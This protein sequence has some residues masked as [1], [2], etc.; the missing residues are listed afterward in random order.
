[1]IKNKL[2]AGLCFLLIMACQ[3][4]TKESK[5]EISDVDP[6]SHIQEEAVKRVLKQAIDVAGG[7]DAWINLKSMKYIKHGILYLE[8]STEESNMV[9]LH[10]YNFQPSFSARISWE[11]NTVKHLIDH[12]TEGSFKYENGVK[13]DKSE[14]SVYQSVMSSLY[15]LG[16]PFKLLDKG[17]NLNYRGTT[18]LDDSVQAEVIYASYSPIDNENHSTSD[19]WYYYFK[20]ETGDFLGAMVYHA[21][22]Y[23]YIR[24]LE[25]DTSTSIKWHAHRQS[26]RTDSTRSIAFLRAEFWYSD[27]EVNY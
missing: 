24:N 1:M 6:Y 8:D 13:T 22:T 15:V 25:F 21:P 16:M 3:Q 2:I 20:E 23:A 7:L 4:N 18:V 27:Y 10:E 17:T 9:Q 11:N 12:S 14:N 5:E 26:F 19:E